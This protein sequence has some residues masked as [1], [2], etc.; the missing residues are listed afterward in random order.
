MQI[1]GDKQELDSRAPLACSPA[2]DDRE[3]KKFRTAI[4]T[5]ISKKIRKSVEDRAFREWK[6]RWTVK[7][8]AEQEKD[9]EAQEIAREERDIAREE[10]AETERQVEQDKAEQVQ[11]LFLKAYSAE[12][13][14]TPIESTAARHASEVAGNADIEREFES[15]WL[16][17]FDA[18][19]SRATDSESRAYA[20]ARSNWVKRLLIEP[21]E[22]LLG[23]MIIFL[24]GAYVIGLSNGIYRAMQAE[25]S[26]GDLANGV[27]AAYGTLGSIFIYARRIDANQKK[28][29]EEYKELV[30]IREKYKSEKRDGLL[31]GAKMKWRGRKANAHL[32]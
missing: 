1:G 15:L 16:S 12:S 24:V 21:G 18:E 14:A 28:K 3:L 23:M 7:E 11:L 30:D 29:E 27:V 25:A 17:A 6:A 9:W 2:P 8:L 10:R 31:I 20:E 32:R 26:Y 22:S 19:F 5:I 13:N 4:V